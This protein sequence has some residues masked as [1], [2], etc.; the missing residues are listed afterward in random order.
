MTDASRPDLDESL[1]SAYLDDELDAHERAA[2]DARLSESAEWRAVLDELR[3]T[4]TALR[5]L[6]LIDGPQEFWTRV[7]DDEAVVID[8]AAASR[9]RGSM[10]RRMGAA[11]AVAAAV[12]GVAFVPRLERVHPPIAAFTHAHA[13]RSSIDNDAVNSL[14][15]SVVPTGLEP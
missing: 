1:L 3:G 15:G 13:E 6:P 7:L 14:A 8:L 2:V 5:N 11:A 9:R 12:F 4:R 10:L